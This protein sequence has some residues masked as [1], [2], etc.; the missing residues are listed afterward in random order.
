[1]TAH[2]G[3]ISTVGKV[4]AETVRPGR[5]GAQRGVPD[6]GNATYGGQDRLDVEAVRP[7]SYLRRIVLTAQMGRDTG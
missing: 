3:R 4:Q 6:A 5:G 7:F 2:L 1:M